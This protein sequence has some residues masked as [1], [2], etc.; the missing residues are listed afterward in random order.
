MGA[1]NTCDMLTADGPRQFVRHGIDGLL[2]PIDDV[3]A[4][5][6]S[7]ARLQSDHNLAQELVQ[8]GF[9]RYE[10]EFTV[11]QCVGQYLK[12]YEDI[13]RRESIIR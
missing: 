6:G 8:N 5:T 3:G 12:Y 11:D 2:F 10:R 13:L 9:A 7:I 1:K 4:L